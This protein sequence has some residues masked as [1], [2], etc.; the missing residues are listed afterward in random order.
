MKTSFILFTDEYP[1]YKIKLDSGCLVSFKNENNM[2][3]AVWIKNRSSVITAA[4][5]IIKHFKTIKNIRV[6]GD[7]KFLLELETHFS[8]NNY[9]IETS[10]A[11]QLP[12]DLIIN[13]QAQKMSVIKSEDIN[14][15][16]TAVLPKQMDRSSKDQK[17]KILIVDDSETIQKILSKII[18]SDSSM[19]VVAC[20]SS[21]TQALDFI[22][23][24]TIDVI[25]LDIHMPEMDGVTLLKNY[26]DKYPIPTVIVSSISMDDGPI[27]L[28]ALEAGAIDYIQKPSLS[29]I[30]SLGPVIV[31]KI[32]SASTAKVN[33]RKQEKI[34]K[35]KQV[36]NENEYENSLVVIGS[37]TG[38]T[39]ALKEVF[40]NFPNQ[41]PPV[42]V[43]QHIPKHFSK[44]FANRLNDMFD[45][46]VKEAEDGDEVKKNQIL[47]APGGNQMK[48]VKSGS[49]L[50]VQIN[51]D[52][53]V[54]RHSPSVDY[55]FY[56]VAEL[57]LPNIIS[58][59]LTGMGADGAKGMLS[60]KLKGAQ[61]IAQSEETCVV[62]GMPKEAI[63][64]GAAND[65]LPLNEIAG[66]IIELSS[67]KHRKSVA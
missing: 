35:N 58:V 54:N 18:T 38:G 51:N 55:F 10:S 28:S 53:P 14:L 5:Q 32:K 62:F 34:K 31:D 39:E 3:Y 22:K 12:I 60:L 59:I 24:N 36:I 50:R 67:L 64:A 20:I 19:E 40:M 52:P 42:L 25:T 37:S 41:I 57:S 46:I 63:R 9:K 11:R 23:N 16:P 26:I 6:V 66:R 29:E 17:I 4:E 45:F 56:S 15:Q 49:H 7:E 48:L 27:V 47:I 1:Q 61:T 13:I 8:N 44:A 2:Y 65:V 43:V 30:T 33:L 21:P